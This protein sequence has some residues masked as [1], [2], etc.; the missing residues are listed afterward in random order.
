MGLKWGQKWGLMYFHPLCT[1]NPPFN[2]F[3]PFQDIDQK[4]R[5][6]K[7]FSQNEDRILFPTPTP[8]FLNEDF[9]LEPGRG[10]KFLLRRTWPGQK[11]LPL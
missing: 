4:L 6:N 1:E 5:R 11:L 3:W 7:L 8:D 9:H 2:H 10:W